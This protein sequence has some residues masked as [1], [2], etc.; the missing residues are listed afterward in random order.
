MRFNLN[1]SGSGPGVGT[2]AVDALTEIALRAIAIDF[3]TA[4]ERRDSACAIGLAWIDDGRVSR[5]EYRLIR[6]PELRF[7]PGNIRVHG[8]YPEQVVNEPEFP[9]IW[10]A[11]S[12]DIG[13]R[14]FIAHNASFD[15][16]VLA[17]MLACYGLPDPDLRFACSL[18]MARRAWPDLPSHRLNMVSQFLGVRFQHHHAGEDAFACAQIAIAAVREMGEAVFEPAR[19]RSPRRGAVT[20]G[21][22]PGRRAAVPKAANTAAAMAQPVVTVRGSRGDAWQV[23]VGMGAGGGASCSCPAGRF[24]R[25]CRHVQALADGV[26][27]DVIRCENIELADALLTIRAGTRFS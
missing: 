12:G 8:I 20:P 17:Q 22:T 4:N 5:R 21:T 16:A 19:A 18:Q 24:G 23:R 3:E 11:F 1:V 27:D 15:S 7:H 25:M 9:E 2:S 10:S 14:L 13:G 26:V 6:P